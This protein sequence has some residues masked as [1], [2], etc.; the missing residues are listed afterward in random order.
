MD[1]NIFHIINRGVEKRK[2]FL[3]NRDYT[4]FIHNISDFNSVDNALQS[5]TRQRN[6]N[7]TEVRPPSKQLVDIPLP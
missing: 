2:I 1:K 4:S 6:D 3:A 5:Y 7:L